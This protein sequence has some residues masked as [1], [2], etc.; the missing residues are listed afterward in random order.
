MSGNVWENLSVPLSTWYLS[1]QVCTCDTRTVWCSKSHF[2]RLRQI[3]D[4]GPGHVQCY[5]NCGL[6]HGN[7][8]SYS[9]SSMAGLHEFAAWQS[10]TSI[11]PLRCFAT[12]NIVLAAQ[13]RRVALKYL[14][15]PRYSLQSSVVAFTG[16]GLLSTGS[17]RYHGI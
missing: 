1:Q 16:T 17:L 6:A 5:S 3:P 9:I 11:M 4:G 14:Y 2:F 13:D 12:A 10:L 8:R 15:K 7:T